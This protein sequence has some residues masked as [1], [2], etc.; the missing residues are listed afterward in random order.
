MHN[1]PSG[2]ESHFKV[3]VIS[4]KFDKMN[5]IGRHRLVHETLSEELCGSIHALSIQVSLMEISLCY[6]YT[7]C[8]LKTDMVSRINDDIIPLTKNGQYGMGYGGRESNLCN[9][10]NRSI[11]VSAKVFRTCLVYTTRRM[12][13]P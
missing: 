7:T 10:H 9:P 13:I 8:S 12:D 4:D 3:V 11:T 1:V 5:L 2:S 6:V